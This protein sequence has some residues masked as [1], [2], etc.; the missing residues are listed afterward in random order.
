MVEILLIILLIIGLFSIYLQ[1]Q[2]KPKGDSNIKFQTT[3]EEK[4]KNIHDEIGRNRE[5]SNKTS[6][7]NRQ[8]L[9]KTLNQFEEKFAKNIN[10]V[11]ETINNQLKD[12]RDDNTKQLEKMRET[13][14]EKLQKTLEKRIGESFKL[15]SER[16]EEVHKGLGEMQNIATGVGDLKKVL[17]KY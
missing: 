7:E 1:L 6:F 14:D 2:N 4:I 8:E 5:E 13:V 16:L 11:K 10:D 17:S 3:L 12:I 15:V 9:S